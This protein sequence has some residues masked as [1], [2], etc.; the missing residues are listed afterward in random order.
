MRRLLLIAMVLLGNYS[1]AQTIDALEYFFDADPGIGNGTP[2]VVQSNSGA[3]TQTFSIPTTGLSEGLH[4]FY[5]RSRTVDGNWSLYDR[6]VFLVNSFSTITQP[7]NEA[8][9]FFDSDPGAG[10]GT[11]ISLDSNAGSIKQAFSIPITGLSQ[12][13][14]SL[15]IRTRST[16]GMW[17]LYDRSIFFINSFATDEEPIVAAEYFYDTDPGI[18]NATA[19]ALNENTGTLNQGVLLATSGL[20]EGLHIVY[21]RVRTESG[22]WSLYDSTSFTISNGAIDNSVTLND[23]TLTARFSAIGVTYRWLDCSSG[24]SFI[25]NAINQSFTPPRSGMYAVEITLGNQ[26]VISNCIEVVL[27]ANENDTDQDG[28]S[29]ADD[30]CPNTP[31]GA[32]VDVDGCQIFSLPSDNFTV[33]TTGESCINS[34]NGSLEITAENP[35][36]YTAILTGDGLNMVNEFTTSSIFSNLSAGEYSVCLAVDGE[37]DYERCFDITI[38]QPEALSVS[39]KIDPSGKE[40][41][42]TLSGSSRYVIELNDK[43]YST[44]ESKITLA[45]NDITNTLSVTTNKSCQGKYE[46]NLVLATDLLVYPNP[47][48]DEPLRIFL[49]SVGKFDEIEVTIFNP[50][51]ILE[52]KNTAEPSEG[53][54]SLD[55]SHL[56]AGVYFLNLK[57]ENRVL[58]YKIVKR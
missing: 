2:L 10:N 26:S 53:F 33:K 7:L 16:Q 42:L 36:N 55:V 37:G 38:T 41:T 28:V 11:A 9:Y 40:V 52:Y 13:F 5:M 1:H 18:G 39:S 54:L 44:S 6:T 32:I 21:I 49:G 29:D 22:S 4:S 23:L 43:I 12:G 27:P 48:A 58:T 50:S 46:E 24:N 17:S 3:L 34:N 30:I 45:L 14:H 31:I 35:L 15:Y 51:G 56:S 19:I 47:V 8:E 25:E 20:T 57:S